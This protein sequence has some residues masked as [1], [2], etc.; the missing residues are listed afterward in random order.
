MQNIII[1]NQLIVV[2]DTKRARNNMNEWIDE[3]GVVFTADKTKLLKAYDQLIEY[4]IP[5]GVT[6]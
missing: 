4:T 1:N 5:K 6:I 3:Y 2:H